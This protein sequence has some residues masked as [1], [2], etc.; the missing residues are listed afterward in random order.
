M[1]EVSPRLALPLL[2]AGQAQ[3]EMFH[4]E[5]LTLIDLLAHCSAAEIGGNLPP[6]DPQPG[7]CWIVGSAPAG[8]WAGRSDAIAGWTEGGWRFV[9]PQEGM[10]VW[11][12]VDRGFAMFTN[13][14]WRSGAT[15]GKVFVEGAQVVGSQ[16][17]AIAEPAGGVTVD[18]EARAAIVAVLEAL[19]SHGLI[20]T[21]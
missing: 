6:G 8:A 15:F 14:E 9:A 19:R 1:N 17:P 3:K 10:H 5:A 13:G 16:A 4:N 2:H 7:Q 12:G 18:G 11:A 21:D 20:A